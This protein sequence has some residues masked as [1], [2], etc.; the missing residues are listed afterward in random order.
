MKVLRDNGGYR[1]KVWKE[2]CYGQAEPLED[3]K[4]WVK[5][6]RYHLGF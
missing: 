1:G 4:N 6:W 5:W 2:V 3:V